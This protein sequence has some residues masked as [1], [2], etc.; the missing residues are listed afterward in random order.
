MILWKTVSIETNQV[1]A[2][3]DP[4]PKLE[5]VDPLTARV[6]HAL[7]QV[8]HLNRLVVAQTMSHHGVQ[9]PEATTLTLLVGN[10]GISQRELAEALH[11]SH[12]RVSMILN[13]LEKSGAVERR[14]DE[15][16]RRV[17][18]IYVTDEG[19]SREGHQRA[20]LGKYVE[21]TLG[22]LSEA[23]RLELE[24]L[25]NQ[26]ADS[27]KAVLRDEHQAKSGGEDVRTR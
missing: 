26:L 15:S 22:V 27:I 25:L 19:R 4:K 17:V 7:G 10:D 1:V 11:L 6:F 12:P 24:R 9:F 2:M 21:R 3:L 20:V 14:P 13:A 5:D 16:D 23:D 18:R 8:M